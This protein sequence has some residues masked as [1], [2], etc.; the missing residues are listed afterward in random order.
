MCY[1]KIYFH[2]FREL[3]PLP[4]IAIRVSPK[5]LISVW[6]L[7]LSVKLFVCIKRRLLWLSTIFKIC[8]LNESLFCYFRLSYPQPH[9]SLRNYAPINSPSPHIPKLRK[10]IS[11]S[12]YCERFINLLMPSFYTYFTTVQILSKRWFTLVYVTELL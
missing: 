11:S 3:R 6:S 12:I 4:W 1:N 7:F 9:W 10:H 8:K 5:G 2:Y